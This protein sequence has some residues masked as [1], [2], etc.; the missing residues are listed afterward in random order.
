MKSLKSTIVLFTLFVFFTSS[1]FSDIDLNQIDDLH[2]SAPVSVSMFYLDL[3]QSDFI[4]QFGNEKIEISDESEIHMEEFLSQN[5]NNQVIF[6]IIVS[7]LIHRDYLLKFEFYDVAEELLMS[8]DEIEINSEEVNI[9]TQIL[10]NND[11]FDKLLVTN[12]VRVSITMLE[13][14]PLRPF[15]DR[16]LIM[17]SSINFDY[18]Y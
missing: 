4:D 7:N 10:F 8:T 2:M 14:T 16:H 6:K 11:R 5:L 1:C 18:E 12:K 15:L 3:E 17:S 13:G 9:E